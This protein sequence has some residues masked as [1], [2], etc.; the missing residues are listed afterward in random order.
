MDQTALVV[1]QLPPVN[2]LHQALIPLRI[3]LALQRWRTMICQ[4]HQGTVWTISLQ[5]R[6]RQE[7]DLLRI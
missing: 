5:L 4:S 2:I 7:T 3:R 6:R 1:R